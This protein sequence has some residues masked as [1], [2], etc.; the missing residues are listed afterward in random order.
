MRGLVRP[1][2]VPED[3]SRPKGSPK[4]KPAFSASLVESLTAQ[5]SA[6]ISA[7]LSERPDIALAA[8]AY[9][10][11]SGVFYPAA[12]LR[13]ACRSRSNSPI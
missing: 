8:V 3:D 2:D 13:T 6:A 10:L 12:A 7:S 1:E 4:V 9:A 11:S 5:K